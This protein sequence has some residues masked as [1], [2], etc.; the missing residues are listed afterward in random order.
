[1]EGVR[2]G[3]FDKARAVWLCILVLR[4]DMGASGRQV[5][6]RLVAAA[7]ACC[8]LWATLSPREGGWQSVSGPRR[9]EAGAGSLLAA[10]AG[11]QAEASVE[12]SRKPVS[13]PQE[14][15]VLLWSRNAIWLEAPR[16]A[17]G[18]L[19]HRIP[20]ESEPLSHGW[21]RG[22]PSPRAV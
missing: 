15:Q 18:D 5:C 6:A 2:A 8:F 17:H 12:T 1:M 20:W 11:A 3:R 19:G 10:Q 13:K 4:S 22:P 7:V 16:T 21:D 14:G 9:D